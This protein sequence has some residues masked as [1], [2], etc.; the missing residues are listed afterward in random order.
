MCT[1]KR[2]DADFNDKITD[3]K[4]QKITTTI[5]EKRSSGNERVKKR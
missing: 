3:I 2:G 4:F 1:L 5:G